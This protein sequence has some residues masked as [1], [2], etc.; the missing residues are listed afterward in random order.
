MLDAL[1]RV[2]AAALA[3]PLRAL[4]A[5]VAYE[6]ESLQRLQKLLDIAET[7]G[8]SDRRH[9]EGIADTATIRLAQRI[10]TGTGDV[11]QARLELQNGM[12]IA[13]RVQKEGHTPSNHGDFVDNVLRRM[14]CGFSR[15]CSEPCSEIVI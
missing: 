12:N 7:K 5:Q 1:E 13:V 9:A 10:A 2:L 4:S 11:G 8:M 15:R 6:T 14:A 3:E